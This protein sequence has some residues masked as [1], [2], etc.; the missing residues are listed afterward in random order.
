MKHESQNYSLIPGL[1]N[2]YVLAGTKTILI[3]LYISI[4]TLEAPGALSVS[5]HILRGIFFPWAVGLSSG[6]QMFSKLCC[7][8][9]CYY[10]GF[11]FPFIEHRQSRFSIILKGPRIF[12]MVN[13]HWLQLQVTGALAHNNKSGCPLKLRSQASTSLSSYE[14]HGIFFQY[15]TVKSILK[16]CCLVQLVSNF[17]SAAFFTSLSLQRI[18]ES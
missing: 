9:M 3:S 15:K 8:Q 16:I 18:K 4:R 10:P 6:L 14:S 12:K 7:K 13:E 17:S 5:S 2:G 11:A 1:Q